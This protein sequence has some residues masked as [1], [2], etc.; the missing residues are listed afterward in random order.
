MSQAPKIAD[1]TK[2]LSYTTGT[3][4]FLLEGSINGFSSFASSFDNGD[5]IFYAA[6][7]GTDYE[8]GSGVFTDSS[9]DTIS[10]FVLAS[11]NSNNLVSFSAGAKEV[12]STYP[13]TNAV[14]SLSGV[15]PKS[16]GVTFW[17]SD[18]TIGHDS[19]FV[20]NSVDNRL[21]INQLNP[22]FSIDIGG[23]PAFS[24]IHTSGIHTGVSGILFASGTT[25]PAYIGGRQLEHFERNILG[26]ANIQSVIELSGVVDQYLFLKPQD[27]GLIFA[28]P[29]SGCGVG[30]PPARPS[31]RT[32]V[33]SDVPDLIF[34]SGQLMTSGVTNA[35]NIAAVSGMMV[36][37]PSG[38][39][40]YLARWSDDDTL[41]A[42]SVYESGGV[43]GIGTDNPSNG[44]KLDVRNGDILVGTKLVVGSGV[45]SA[46]SPGA[47]FGLKHTQMDSAD[48]YMIMSAGSHTYISAEDM[49]NVYIRGGGNKHD[50]QIS[51]HES[52]ITLG[53]YRPA[54]S[55]VVPEHDVDIVY[56][57]GNCIRIADR[58]GSGVML[59]DCALSASTVY[60]GM[61]H[62]EMAGTLDYMIASSGTHT[63]ISARDGSDVFIRGGGNSAECQISVLDV[64]AGSVGI[65]FN[66][67]G[68]DR[69]LRMEGAS[70]DNLFRIDASE[71]RIGIGTDIPQSTLDVSGVITADSGV[72]NVLD[73]NLTSQAN[74]PSH[75][76]GRVWYD[77]TSHS[78]VVYNDESQ[79]AQ[80]LGQEEY[81]RVYN[82]TGSTILNGSGVRI[83][84]SYANTAPTIA[85]AIANSES[86]SKVV[87]LVT[88][89]IEN[90]SYGY[91]TTYGIVSGVNTAAF[92]AGDEL[93]LSPTAT[94]SYTNT[95]PEIP[96]YSS[97]L[98]YVVRE[99][100]DG[101]VLVQLGKHKLGGG[102][103]KAMDQGVHVSGIPFIDGSGYGNAIGLANVNNFVYDSGSARLGIGTSH[104]TSTVSVSGQLEALEILQSG[105][106]I[107]LDTDL[108]HT[109]GMIDSVSG[110][111][112]L[113]GTIATTG[114]AGTPGQIRWDANYIY[115]CVAANSWKRVQINTW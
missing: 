25:A 63:F 93:F 64:G 90:N 9:T 16:S 91:V 31:F 23:T 38:V 18:K 70:N 84:G 71:D 30:C 60:A 55:S 57:D 108:V 107:A 85:Y 51:V 92:T 113:Q 56:D 104:P 36:D 29:A 37:T 65:V 3:S 96:N 24:T 100:T 82:S 20:W 111:M 97:P 7:D 49:K 101:S 81:L 6:T 88:H 32:L 34:I 33:L 59:G 58:N 15:V 12:Y 17:L 44:Y 43:V 102:D 112:P 11:S 28:G 98:G 26:D 89:D 109:S 61:K 50:H 54:A 4:A 39:H 19:N 22:S 87:G 103:I 79:V 80:Q 41:G 68:A 67:N 53:K 52:G 94:G 75:S 99:A 2:E 21:G 66:D 73:L 72:Y 47:Y 115:V 13:A 5:V 114:T 27:T 106:S 14:M 78:L 69:D 1:R 45:Y 77:S 83:T 76:E 62:T 42:S 86:N 74:H 110:N 35:E 105:S 95:S 46:S 48:E 40:S 10:R 8:V